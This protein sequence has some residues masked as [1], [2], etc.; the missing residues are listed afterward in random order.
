V[1]NAK[2][3]NEI[4]ELV[5]S[6]LDTLGYQLDAM[7]VE[8]QINRHNLIALLMFGQK[9]FEGEVDS[10]GAKIDTGIAKVDALSNAAE[11]L[12]KS[13]INLAMFPAK[14]TYD[15]VKSQF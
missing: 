13:G 8:N 6:Q 11:E 2:K 15:R 9:R 12:L 3:I 4:A 1:K 5:L 7:G 10:V 14:Y